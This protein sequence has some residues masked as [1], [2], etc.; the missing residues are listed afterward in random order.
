MDAPIAQGWRRW[1]RLTIVLLADLAL[2]NF[3]LCLTLTLNYG[4]IL[5]PAAL[6]V[7]K[8][9]AVP[10]T[11]VAGVMMF[12]RGLYRV[13]ARYYGMYD[14]LSIAFVCALL[15]TLLGGLEVAFPSYIDHTR[16]LETP[17]LFGL[18]AIALL[19]GARI[20]RRAVAWRVIPLARAREE[21]LRKR[22]IVVGAGDAG[23]ALV[24]EMSRSRFSNYFVVGFAD[25]D[26]EKA[27]MRIHGIRV[28]GKTEDIPKLVDEFVVAEVIIAIPNAD[29]P[30]MRRIVDLCNRSGARVRTMPVVAS[31]L[32]GDVQTFKHLRNVEIEDLLKRPAVK[33]DLSGVAKYVNGERVLITGAGGSIGSEL[34]RQIAN[35]S[36]SSLILLG[37][38]ENSIFEIEQELLRTRGLQPR[39]IIAD[40]RDAKAIDRAFAA[41]QPTVVFHA[42]AHKHVPL[43]ESN[44]LEAIDNNIRGTWVTAET[45]VRHGVKKFIY[46]STDK[47]VKPSSVM[48]ATKRIGEM[49]VASIGHQTEMETAIVRFGNVL[50][51]RGSLIPMLK[52]QIKS[53]GPVRLTHED[54]TRYFMTIPEA[55]QLILQAGALGQRGDVFILDMGEPMRIVDLA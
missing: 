39:C 27:N 11:A 33:T 8:G 5:D 14:F 51:S 31:V 55:V 12:W 30:T 46:V 4:S 9:Y 29:G 35:Y 23:E 45:S 13:S 53:G 1:L 10:I 18:I 52:A 40:V 34:A 2:V 22:A 41:Y 54:M 20:A 21:K 47:A 17:V 7:L 25:D 50:G 32:R 37:K 49:L 42:A 38:G 15:A 6:L 16:T 44:L 24:R 28:L 43:M 3:S 48:G 36:P 19:S 26:S